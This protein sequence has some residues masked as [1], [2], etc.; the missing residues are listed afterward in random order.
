MITTV[1]GGRP[2]I[3]SLL[4]GL[5]AWWGLHED[6]KPYSA[7]SIANSRLDSSGNNR[8]L[9]EQ[10]GSIAIGTIGGGPKGNSALF[11]NTSNILAVALSSPAVTNSAF[12]FSIWFK[13][14]DVSQ[15][16]SIMHQVITSRPRITAGAS[17]IVW[18]TGGSPNYVLDSTLPTLNQW[19]HVVGTRDTA[20]GASAQIK[21]YINGVLST[22]A[23]IGRAHV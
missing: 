16:Y 5:F 22:W 8:H 3:E 19:Y 2:R 7:S 10:S 13:L 20:V 21:L 9:T 12:T 14:Y 1:M 18:G 11:G 15:D 6:A 4:N 17:G 23:K